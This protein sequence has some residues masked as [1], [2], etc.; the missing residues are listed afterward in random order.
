MDQI[1][2]DRTVRETRDIMNEDVALPEY[3][4]VTKE[5]G[6]MKSFH[7]GYS[8]VE[9]PIE[10]I[11][12]AT[13]A[14]ELARRE[15]SVLV[16]GEQKEYRYFEM[17][18][19]DQGAAIANFLNYVSPNALNWYKSDK[20]GTPYS[21]EYVNSK[22]L[23][24]PTTGYSQCKAVDPQTGED[25]RQLTLTEA[26]KYAL[27]EYVQTCENNEYFQEAMVEFVKKDME[28]FQAGLE[29]LQQQSLLTIPQSFE[30]T[31]Q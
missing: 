21:Y 28:V 26:Y 13:L 1:C 22:V 17:L 18:N 7:F 25:Y 11:G 31:E 27:G 19:H 5:L 30:A 15:F 2:L 6:G 4:W 12:F 29:N 9:L 3:I 14:A 20:D 10:H 16:R 24:E 23:R 8:K